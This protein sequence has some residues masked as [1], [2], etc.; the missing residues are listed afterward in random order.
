MRGIRVLEE[1]DPRVRHSV[2]LAVRPRHEL[3][4]RRPYEPRISW[5]QAWADRR[6]L[7]QLLIDLRKDDTLVG[8]REDRIV[9]Q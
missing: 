2:V 8:G 9:E 1:I 7:L 5:L 3:R 6:T 4:D